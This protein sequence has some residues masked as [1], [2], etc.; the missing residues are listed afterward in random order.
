MNFAKAMN[1]PNIIMSARA[2]TTPLV[3]T[4]NGA[5]SYANPDPSGKYT[6]RLSLFFKAVRNLS[7]PQLYQ[8]LHTASQESI[9]DTFLLAFHLRDSRGGKGER[10]LGRHA[11]VWLFLNFPAEFR[12][13]MSLLPTYGR[14]DDLVQ[15]FP[16][17]LKLDNLEFVKTNYGSESLTEDNLVV[18]RQLQTDMVKMVGDQL[19]EDRKNM[20]EGKSCTLCAKWSPTEGDSLDRKANTYRTLADS[21]NISLAKLRKDYNTPLRSY[22]KVVESYICSGH[23]DKVDFNK[24]PSCAMK[25][26]KKAFEKHQPERF[27]EWKAKLKLNDPKVAKVNAKQLFP[28]ELVREVRQK[29]HEDELIEAQWRVLVDEVKKLGSLKDTV[30]VVDT[31]GSMSMPDNIPLDVAVALGLIIS[32]V[33]QGPFHGQ[34]INFNTSPI[35]CTVPDGSMYS[36]W[37]V[38]NHLPWGGSTNLEATFRMI[39]E[40]GREAKL[41]QEDMPKRLVIISDMQFNQVD[42]KFSTNMDK[43]NEMYLQAGYTRPNI[44]FWNVNSSSNEFPVTT[45]EKGTV[46]ISGFSPS[47]LEALIKGGD[48]TSVG[49]MNQALE[50]ARYNPVRVALGES[51]SLSSEYEVVSDA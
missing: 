39:L 26:L 19:V 27:T 32:E 47:I 46:M 1:V 5:L 15:F 50:N 30:V 25:K 40:R 3:F 20:L 12:K 13:V 21:M 41:T 49:V 51:V 34:V 45:D 28:H 7:V 37:N 38:V 10:N 44:V 17:V 22:L 33:V 29:H 14:Y 31:S 8:F 35:F 48:F 9:L 23:W 18:L 43:I 16:S 2:Q 11:L 42:H 36:R 4:N 6:G 24:V